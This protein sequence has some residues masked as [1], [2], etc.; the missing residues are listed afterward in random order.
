M[1]GILVVWA[2]AVRDFFFFF[3]CL[4]ELVVARVDKC[5]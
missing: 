2:F 3:D 5:S 1:G 4:R